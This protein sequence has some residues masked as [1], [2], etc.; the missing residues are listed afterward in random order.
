MGFFSVDHA[1]EVHQE[2]QE[3][4][5]PAWDCTLIKKMK[6]HKDTICN[7]I[8]TWED[9]DVWDFIKD[10]G[11]TTNPLYE[12]GF[13]RVGCVGCPLARKEEREKEFELFPTYKQA[14]I[15]AFD[16]MIAKRE[17][18]DVKTDW[19]NGE[20]VFNWWQ[21]YDSDTIEGQMSLFD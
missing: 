7:A 16:K 20:E 19:K 14:Y 15:N 17:Q 5:D 1:E 10:R 8:Y 9:A 12:I 18:R 13:V 2:S 3:I 4:N 21:E 11:I 6:E